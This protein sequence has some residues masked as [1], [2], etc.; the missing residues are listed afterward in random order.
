MCWASGSSGSSGGSDFEAKEKK[1]TKLWENEVGGRVDSVGV[2]GVGV[3]V[4]GGVGRVVVG[5]E[6]EQE[7]W[8]WWWWW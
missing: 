7:W 3:G 6:R 4:M 1:L 2:L 8:W 5:K